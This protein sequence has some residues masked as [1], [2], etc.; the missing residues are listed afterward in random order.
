MSEAIQ[1]IT[2]KF[3]KIHDF[4]KTAEA[5]KSIIETLVERNPSVDVEF[6]NEAIEQERHRRNN[7]EIE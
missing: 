2:S 1:I 5:I 3:E 4:E 6:L 7:S